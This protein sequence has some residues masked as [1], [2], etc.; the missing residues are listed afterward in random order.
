MHSH[1]PEDAEKEWSRENDESSIDYDSGRDD[2][3][4]FDAKHLQEG[5]LGW[6]I[7]R[8]RVS[9]ARVI[10]VL[11]TFTQAKRWTITQPRKSHYTIAICFAL[12]TFS[13]FI[14]FSRPTP[15]ELIDPAIANATT[16]PLGYNRIITAS[17]LFGMTSP[18]YKR[19]IET[20]KRQAQRWNYTA[21]ILER[22]EGCGVWTKLIFLLNLVGQ[23]MQ[24]PADTRAEWIMWS[25]ADAL[26]LN[27]NIPLSIFLPPPDL[28]HIHFVGTKDWNGFNA[29][30]FFVRVHPWII[31]LFTSAM[32]FPICH[33]DTDLRGLAEQEAIR[34]SFERENG[35]K[36]DKGWRS[37]IVFMPRTWFNAYELFQGEIRGS[38][39]YN[40]I[41]KTAITTYSG[42]EMNHKFEGVRGSMVAHFAGVDG[43][44]RQRL[45]DDWMN[46]I[47]EERSMQYPSGN[48]TTRNTSIDMVEF[49]QM[50][51]I[52]EHDAT[53][54]GT[55][56][57]TLPVHQTPLLNETITFWGR[58]REA[59]ALSNEAVSSGVHDISVIKS[60]LDLRNALADNM[61]Q[62]D[63]VDKKI[64]HLKDLMETRRLN[65]ASMLD[66][67]L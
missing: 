15:S 38:D 30:V 50:T 11:P 5:S 44:V 35:G 65:L 14:Y 1:E 43:K 57:W 46:V 66:P 39:Y 67:M 42:L 37:G 59:M 61:D 10:L 58:Y 55:S 26:I 64:E 31:S 45:M 52:W 4:L 32:S 28:P 60:A 49:D 56:L 19:A 25:D 47:D 51:E 40:K 17:M 53:A 16:L 12:L 33:Q 13:G 8:A 2:F 6:T 62:P 9:M 63:V 7:R 27:P 3:S 36:D 41:M 22:D 23:E 24:K 21:E 48:S 29:G 20:H 54:N 34:L 18:T